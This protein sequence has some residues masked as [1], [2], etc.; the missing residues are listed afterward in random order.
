MKPT[1]DVINL[2]TL[3][4]LSPFD[5]HVIQ[6]CGNFRHLSHVNFPVREG[7]S[8]IRKSFHL[9]NIIIIIMRTTSPRSSYHKTKE[10]VYNIEMRM[11]YCYLLAF[12][13]STI[14]PP[15]TYLTLPSI[16][17]IITCRA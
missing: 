11:V 8:A 13:P 7:L 16:E 15:R 5:L 17:N 9:I 4:I 2:L 6:P 1:S 12:E 14:D 3:I 10:T